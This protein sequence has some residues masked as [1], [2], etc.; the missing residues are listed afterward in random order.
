MTSS[1]IEVSCKRKLLSC[2]TITSIA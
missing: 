1:T 2:R